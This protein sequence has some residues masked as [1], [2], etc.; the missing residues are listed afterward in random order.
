[1]LYRN[2]QCNILQR[3]RRGRSF[4]YGHDKFLWV[5]ERLPGCLVSFDTYQTYGLNVLTNQVWYSIV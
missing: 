1:M 5:M 3:L 4:Y 2:L